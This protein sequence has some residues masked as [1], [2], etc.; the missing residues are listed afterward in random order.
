MRRTQVAY[1]VQ[2]VPFII[3]Y[4]ID[5]GT[6]PNFT[7]F[8]DGVVIAAP[9]NA[10]T[11]SGATDLLPALP[12]GVHPVTVHGFN[13]FGAVTLNVNFT[14]DEPIVDA[15]STASAVET[16]RRAHSVTMC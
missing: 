13:M 7:L 9:Y 16:V 6:N 2:G 11:L 12:L 15:G 3:E 4:L 8:F 14:I 5:K 1:A 10:S